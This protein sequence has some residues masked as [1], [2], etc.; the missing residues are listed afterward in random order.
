VVWINSLDD[1][2]FNNPTQGVDCYCDLLIEANDLILQAIVTPSPTGQYSLLIEVMQPDGLVVFEDAT[3]YFE[4]YVFQGV[5]GVFYM[6]MRAKRFSPAMCA[7]SCFILRVT[8]NRIE[9]ISSGGGVVSVP[10]VIFQKY[11]ERYCIDNCCVLAKDITIVSQGVTDLGE[12]DALDYNI[13]D[14][15]AS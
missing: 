6:N 3:M 7:N 2:Q 11:T 12:Y 5:N 10:R 13:N 4:W 8:I 15:L 9:W 1:L 14:Y